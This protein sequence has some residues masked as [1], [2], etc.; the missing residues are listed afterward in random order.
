MSPII[1]AALIG[2]L[3]MTVSSTALAEPVTLD[4][5]IARAIQAAPLVGANEAAVTATEAA[6]RQASVRPNPSLSVESE[7]FVG[8]GGY[9]VFRQAETTITYSQLIE[10]GGKRAA[11]V[12]LAETDVRL[13]QARARTA[14]LEIAAEVQRAYIDAQIAVASL[15]I[16]TDRLRIEQEVQ[17]EALRRVR[18]YKDPLFVETRTAARVA[19][20]TLALREAEARLAAARNRLAAFWGGD[21]T[22]IEVTEGF[23]DQPDVS[24]A[25]A[26]SDGEVTAAQVD[27]ARA[28]V[29]VEQSRLA[30]DY[31]VSGGVRFLRQT[32][33]IAAVAGVTI[34][35]RLSNSNRGNVERAQAE[36][37]QAEFLAEADRLSRLRRLASLRADADAARMRANGIMSQVYPRAVRTLAQ[38]REGYNRGGFRFSDIEDAAN[39]I[40]DTQ[41]SWLDAMNRYR[42]SQTE[43]DRL[44]GRFD[45]AGPGGTNP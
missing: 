25:L 6:R 17:R 13:A 15:R 3:L 44:T 45:V 37:R 1:R 40:I 22:G 38:V 16:A 33:D 35:L 19:D 2:G 26:A 39:A 18:G 5:A 23:S 14:Q 10:R 31:T 20:A 4:Q 8:T 41:A 7:N 36:R 27:R 12:G 11:R 42:D 32:N 9:D 43:I 24:T 29:V 28:A 21:G 30:Q 34:P